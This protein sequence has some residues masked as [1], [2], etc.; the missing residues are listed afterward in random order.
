MRQATELRQR[1]K[2]TFN[3]R[4]STA[5]RIL[6]MS[7][8]EL[9]DEVRDVLDS[10]PL[11]EEVE[12]PLPQ[13]TA[14]HFIG[15]QPTS[16]GMQ[17][18]DLDS[19]ELLEFAAYQMEQPTLRDHLRQQ[20]PA[21]GLSL[22]KRSIAYAIIDSLDERGYLAESPDEIADYLE[23]AVTADEV[24]IVLEVVQQFD[25]PGVAARNLSECLVNQ[26]KLS[27]KPSSL[28]DTA[29]E[30]LHNHLD[31]LAEMQVERISEAMQRSTQEISAA[32]RLIQSL[33]PTPGSLFGELAQAVVPDV[34]VRRIEDQWSVELNPFVLPKLKISESYQAM[35]T[36]QVKK[37]ERDYLQRNLTGA[38]AFLDGVKRRHE[39]VLRVAKTVVA[40]QLPF[41]ESGEQAMRPLTL[42]QVADTLMLHESTVS[43]ACAGKYIMTPRGTFELKHFFSFRIR[44]FNGD[45][46]S[47]LSI[48]HRMRRIVNAENRQ[49]PLS[50]Q[51]IAQQMRD[52]GIS[53]ARRTIAKYRSELHIPA[54]D[55]RKSIA[56]NQLSNQE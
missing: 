5:V 40:H 19:D 45:D 21:S 46:E 1:Q 37:E 32:I 30:I 38:T 9:A 50:D 33:N 22:A 49:A 8:A 17:S 15:E 44:K 28:R 42:R 20:V 48:K 25:P 11:L 34:V 56:V 18:V 41:L 29:R 43:R 23:D 35:M 53:I 51:Q 31:S 16:S 3:A 10:N 7:G 14:D 52:S 36:K 26:L 39:T 27:R 13:A 2:Q 24:E 55:I 4:F 54:R 6:Q 12:Q 47:A